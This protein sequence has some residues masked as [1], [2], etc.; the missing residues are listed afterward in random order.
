MNSKMKKLVAMSLMG[1]TTLTGC[2]GAK[3]YSSIPLE[4]QLTKQEVIDYYAK[5]MS[6]D[7]IVTRHGATKVDLVFTD[8]NETK[9]EEITK[10]YQDIMTQ[11]KSGLK[12]GDV[13]GVEKEDNDTESADDTQKDM[14][15]EA[16]EYLK[17]MLDPY[18]LEDETIKDIK[19]SLGYY[20]VTVDFKVKSKGSDGT[21]KGMINYLGVNGVFVQDENDKV[22]V[23]KSYL[24]RILFDINKKRK[25][26]GLKEY[27]TVKD[28]QEADVKT[29][30]EENEVNNATESTTESEATGIKTDNIYNF[31]STEFDV[32]YIN[33][34]LGT[35]KSSAVMPELSNVFNSTDNGDN[36]GGY[37]I[38]IQGKNGLMDFG[39]TPDSLDGN[40]ELV[41][42]FKQDETKSNKYD[43]AFCYTNGYNSNI[44]LDSKYTEQPVFGEFVQTELNKIVERYDRVINNKDITSIMEGNILDDKKMQLA[45]AF[46]VSNSDIMTYMSNINKVLARSD[47]G[48]VYLVKVE[49]I[50]EESYLKSSS[51]VKYKDTY[52]MVIRQDGIEFKIN[53]YVLANRELLTQPDIDA[54]ESTERRLVALN[55]SGEISEDNKK[56]IQEQLNNLY[57]AVNIRQL[58]DNETED[59]SGNK[60]LNPG[61]YDRFDEDRSLLSSARFDYLTSQVTG[62]S[63]RETAKVGC[64][65]AGIVSQWMGGNDEQAEFITEEIMTY[66]G[67]TKGLYLKQ[68]YLMSNYNGKW[69]IDDIVNIQ[70]LEL[71]GNLLQD[72]IN[73]I[74]GEVAEVGD[75]NFEGTSV[76]LTEKDSKNDSTSK[77]SKD[78]TE[79]KNTAE[80]PESTSEVESTTEPQ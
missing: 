3:D 77:E 23:D 21:L 37:G 72:K 53:D 75:L 8:V 30:K 54:D 11:Y 38:Y 58:Y 7:T 1:A 10:R 70:E 33:N 52:Y 61:V 73:A 2:S 41:F 76:D 71:S 66:D 34:A 48:K 74:G 35:S 24:S 18:I 62:R 20:F 79:V 51:I 56:E 46:Y 39:Y 9:K 43:Y 12:N 50:V 26:D 36:L 32:D 15:V 80:S 31:E 47:D 28:K 22:D 49:R 44:D 14:G 13:V 69:V 6:Y 78:S 40:I 64:K 55:L 17:S 68:Y 19:E 45:N 63:T 57:T 16:H 60:V 42:V 5:E 27:K 25:E 4:A 67:K 65:Y 29:Q 59:E